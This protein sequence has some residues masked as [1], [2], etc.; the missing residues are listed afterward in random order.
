MFALVLKVLILLL[1]Y[2]P[3]RIFYSLTPMPWLPLGAE[4]PYFLYLDINH[5][6]PEVLNLKH[7]QMSYRIKLRGKFDAFI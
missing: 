5:I 7:Y 2:D 4:A 3:S 1:M 6:I